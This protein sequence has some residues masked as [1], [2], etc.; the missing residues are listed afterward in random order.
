MTASLAAT[1]EMLQLS[2]TTT[3]TAAANLNNV[4]TVAADL[5]DE[6]TLT[7]AT[8]DDGLI[9]LESSDIAGT[10]GV[11]LYVETGAIANQFDA[12]DLTVLAI[13]TGDDVVATD[14]I[15]T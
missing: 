12:A 3:A 7:A 4:T 5:E 15:T 2:T 6:I 8:G 14:F 13:V 1:N 10:F 9:V 11:Y